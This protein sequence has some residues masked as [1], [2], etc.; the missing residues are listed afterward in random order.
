MKSLPTRVAANQTTGQIEH[1]LPSHPNRLGIG[2]S[3]LIFGLGLL[4]GGPTGPARAIE[5]Q[6]MV[7]ND[8]VFGNSREDDRYTAALALSLE[9][10]DRRFAFGERMFTDRQAGQRFDETYLTWEK[11]L[12]TWGAWEPEVGLGLLRIGEGLLGEQVQNQIHEAIGSD[13]LALDYPEDTRYFGEISAA[14]ERQ[15]PFWRGSLVRTRLEVRSAPGFRSWMR[16]TTHYEAPLGRSFAWRVGIGLHG[17]DANYRLLERNVDPWGATGE[18][19]LAWQSLT[20]RYSF[21]DLG[22]GTSHLTLGVDVPLG[23]IVFR[24]AGDR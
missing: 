3:A 10:Q 6:V 12:P 15:D 21:N 11:N 5:L 16:I 20:L 1:R 13:L 17:E 14:L 4:V 19:A 22:T 8:P 2:L 7:A 18:I 9:Q 24:E 23:R